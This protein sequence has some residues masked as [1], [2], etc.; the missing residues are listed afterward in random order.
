MRGPLA[1]D[2]LYMWEPS[3]PWMRGPLARV[4]RY[5]AGNHRVAYQ[6]T[7]VVASQPISATPSFGPRLAVR[8]QKP[9]FDA[10]AYQLNP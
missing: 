10:S 6:P 1:D 3:V 2:V 5:V 7:I 8:G 4:L 9:S